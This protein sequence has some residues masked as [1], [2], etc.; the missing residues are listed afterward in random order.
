MIP[1][2]ANALLKAFL[3]ARGKKLALVP[4]GDLTRISVLSL[5]GFLAFRVSLVVAVALGFPTT[6]H[7]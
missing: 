5:L 7:S 1:L 3:V 4:V 2:L 6:V